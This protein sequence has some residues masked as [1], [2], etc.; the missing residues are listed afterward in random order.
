LAPPHIAG[1]AALLYTQGITTPAEIEAVIKGTARDLGARGSDNEYG[2][3]L[4]QL[5]IAMRGIGVT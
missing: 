2:Y 3:G 4:I 1:I 5:R